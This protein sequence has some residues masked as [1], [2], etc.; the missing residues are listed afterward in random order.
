MA[1]PGFSV[2]TDIM[3]QVQIGRY[4]V[5]SRAASTVQDAWQDAG[6]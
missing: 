1:A 2:R 3:S 5:E 4:F 6:K